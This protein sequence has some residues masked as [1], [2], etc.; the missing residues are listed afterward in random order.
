MKKNLKYYEL[1]IVKNKRIQMQNSEIGGKERIT[2]FKSLKKID[3][4]RVFKILD[5]KKVI[6]LKKKVIIKYTE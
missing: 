3:K 4:K 2:L 1:I 5:K 6:L